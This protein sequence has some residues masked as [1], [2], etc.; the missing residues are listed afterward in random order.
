MIVKAIEIRDRRTF[1][2]AI[3]IK[4]VPNMVAVDRSEY[5]AERYLLRRAGYGPA[6][7][8]PPC[9]VLCRMEASGVDRNATYDPYAWGQGTRTYLVAHEYIIEHFD[10]LESGA[11]VDVEFILG[12][13][14]EPKKS[15]RES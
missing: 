3:A 14:K 12:E 9:V 8:Y 2:P 4:M 7:D 13:T 11:V 5:D 15:E 10:Q 6:L 1:I